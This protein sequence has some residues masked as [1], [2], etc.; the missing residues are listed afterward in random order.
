M[1][2]AREI[3]LKWRGFLRIGFE[4]SG[5]KGLDNYFYSNP[6]IGLY[7]RLDLDP[8][9]SL[10]SATVMVKSDGTTPNSLFIRGRFFS[11]LYIEESLS[12]FEGFQNNLVSFLCELAAYKGRLDPK[13][14]GELIGDIERLVLSPTAMIQQWEPILLESGFR[15]VGGNEFSWNDLVR[16][17]F[18]ATHLIAHCYENRE[19]GGLIKSFAFDYRDITLDRHPFKLPVELED[20]LI[21]NYMLPNI[22]RSPS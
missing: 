15:F 11:V 1:T 20:F 2:T 12:D 9:L 21:L 18:R 13:P 8:F 22:Y 5:E 4:W 19:D 6:L 7:I 10:A 17:K 16:V 3:Q 14:F